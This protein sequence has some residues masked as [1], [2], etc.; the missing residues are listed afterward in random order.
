[1]HAT[2]TTPHVTISS[3]IDTIAVKNNSIEYY[4]S[5]DFSAGLAIK[6]FNEKKTI[7]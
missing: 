7:K 4:E 6:F 2:N 3:Q 1:M 5:D